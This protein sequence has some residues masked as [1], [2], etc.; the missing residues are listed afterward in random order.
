[1]LREW[2][3]TFHAEDIKDF[4]R[5]LLWRIEKG[6]FSKPRGQIYGHCQ[7]EMNIAECSCWNWCKE[8]PTCPLLTRYGQDYKRNEEEVEN[9]VPTG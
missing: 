1:M 3:E 7:H 9:A 4:R 5:S 6:L 8:A 2:V